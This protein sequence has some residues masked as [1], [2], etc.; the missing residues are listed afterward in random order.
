MDTMEQVQ[1]EPIQSD[2]SEALPLDKQLDAMTKEELIEYADDVLGYTITPKLLKS[3]ILNNILAIDTDRR[4]Q[5]AKVNAESLKQVVSE[6]DPE[7]EIR[8]F[9]LESPGA[10]E[11]FATSVPKGMYGKEFTNPDG[12]KGGNPNGFKKCP[13]Y[14]LFPGE[15]TKLAYSVYEHLTSLTF[16]THKTVWD[17]ETGMIKGT[18]PIIKPR[19][20]L[21]P[22]FTKE[23]LVKLNK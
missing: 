16:M 9:N 10:D 20:I 8:F 4:R 6:E 19:F 3:V 13:K 1:I 23:Q 5:A 21:Q 7:I 12:S 15:V 22:I 17:T 14:H 11:E 2:L 18:I